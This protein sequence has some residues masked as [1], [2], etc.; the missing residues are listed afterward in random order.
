MS[1]SRQQPHISTRFRQYDTLSRLLQYEAREPLSPDDNTRS[2]LS[3]SM[4]ATMSEIG[5]RW[6]HNFQPRDISWLRQQLNHIG[7]GWRAGATYCFFWIHKFPR[8][9][10]EQLCLLMEALFPESF[11][12]PP[13]EAWANQGRWKAFLEHPAVNTSVR[14]TVLEIALWDHLHA[15]LRGMPAQA[16]PLLE[17]LVSRTEFWTPAATEMLLTKGNP[18]HLHMFATKSPKDELT[19][20]KKE[21]FAKLI[22]DEPRRALQVAKERQ[23]PRPSWME[24]DVWS[25][26]AQ[27]LHHDDSE[28]RAQALRA[29]KHRQNGRSR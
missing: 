1:Q 11:V 9:S 3:N 26:W 24:E 19:E 18:K 27:L 20:P 25:E 22:H 28:I 29:Q 6:G 7:P 8:A 2:T 14:T 23:H 10:S 16:P 4:D 15:D 5:D 12:E 21:V 17:L 13:Y